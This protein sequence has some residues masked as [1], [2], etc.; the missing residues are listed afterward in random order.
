M[1]RLITLCGRFKSSAALQTAFD[2]RH[3]PRAFLLLLE[4]LL[5]VRPSARPS[6][7]RVLSAIREGR[8][9][10]IAQWLCVR[11]ADSCHLLA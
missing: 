8:V 2:S 9:R 10:Y 3:L 6:C 11:N 7:E 4:N 5:H 1:I